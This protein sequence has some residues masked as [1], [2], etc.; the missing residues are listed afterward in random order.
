MKAD[1]QCYAPVTLPPGKRLGTHCTRS[2]VATRV[3][4]DGYGKSLPTRIRSTDH[5]ARN[6]SLY[7]LSY[8]SPPFQHITLV[9][10]LISFVRGNINADKHTFGKMLGTL[11]ISYEPRAADQRNITTLSH[12]RFT[13]DD[14]K[15]RLHE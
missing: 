15:R 4:L 8:P 10:M 9:F 13:R 6:E 3:G 2:W 11:L 14:A 5:R 1:G 12:T 7:R